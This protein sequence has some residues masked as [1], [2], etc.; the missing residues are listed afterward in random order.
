M[1]CLEVKIENR[2]KK[3]SH[4]VKEIEKYK[5]EPDYD[6]ELENIRER[7][8]AREKRKN[9]LCWNCRYPLPPRAKRCPRC[10]EKI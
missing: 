8:R 10:G 1:K 3:A 2:F 6:I 7:I 4:I 5:G 9:E